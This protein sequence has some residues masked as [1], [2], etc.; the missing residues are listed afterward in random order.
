[1]VAD[2]SGDGYPDVIALD[3]TNGKILGW[4][5]DSTAPVTSPAFEALAYF[6]GTLSSEVALVSDLSPSKILEADINTDGFLD[7]LVLSQGGKK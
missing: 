3:K 2:L 4:A 6:A 5:W 1:M 7:L